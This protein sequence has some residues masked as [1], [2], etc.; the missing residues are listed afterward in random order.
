[1]YRLQSIAINMRVDLRRADIAVSQQFL[2]DT[3]IGSAADEMAGEA[4]PQGVG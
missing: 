2:H 4:M 1:M 3:E